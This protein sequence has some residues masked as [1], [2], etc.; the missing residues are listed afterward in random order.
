MIE[1]KV[2]NGSRWALI[3]VS[4]LII[5]T[6]V[7]LGGLFWG[8]KNS[9]NAYQQGYTAGWSAAKLAVDESGI[10]PPEFEEIFD[11]TGEIMS[12]S[13]KNH[14]LTLMVEPFSDNPLA[15]AGPS[16]RVIQIGVDTVLNKKIPKNFEEYLNEQE[17]YDALITS[18]G[19]DDT[20]IGQPPS[21]FTDENAVFED[22][23]VGQTIVIHTLI[24]IKKADKINPESVDIIF[25]E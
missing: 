24:D 20:E 1:Q 8:Q 5:L 16:I 3:I 18:L 19:P 14:T 7:F 2:H 11:M 15:E 10:F 21:P 22:F 9:E 12:I 17:A 23:S 6:A 13:E 25:E 4:L